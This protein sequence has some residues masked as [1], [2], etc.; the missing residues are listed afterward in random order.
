[1]PPTASAGPQAPSRPPPLPRSLAQRPSAPASDPYPT[2]RTDPPGARRQRAQA[3]VACPARSEQLG[4]TP[5]RRHQRGLGRQPERS[6]QG[7][8]DCGCVICAISRR[9]P[10]HSPQR[11]TST[12]N[13]KGQRHRPQAVSKNNHASC[14]TIAGSPSARTLG[15]DPHFA[16]QPG[17]GL[18]MLGQIGIDL[19]GQVLLHL[20]RDSAHEAARITQAVQVVLD[21]LKR[22]LT[23]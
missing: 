15:S 9:R 14:S 5:R 8:H 20:L 6:Q 23:R 18:L 17:E 1:T 3:L 2:Q 22:G 21:Q 19:S 16:R 10:K 11:S 12:A 13:T 7:L 4:R